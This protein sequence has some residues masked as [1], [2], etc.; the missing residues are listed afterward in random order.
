MAT[1][2][3]Q[4]FRAT[5]PRGYRGDSTGGRFIS[6]GEVTV[7]PKMDVQHRVITRALLDKLVEWELAEIVEVP[8]A[9]TPA[10]ESPDEPEQGGN[11][12]PE[13]KP[14]ATRGRTRKT[15]KTD[16]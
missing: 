9:N 10:E 15:A 3:K 14:K 4:P 5:L 11:P 8:E 6:P 16:D 7:G 12:E 13:Q 2:A 1:S